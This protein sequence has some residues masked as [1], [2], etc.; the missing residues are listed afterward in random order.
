[1]FCFCLFQTEDAGEHGSAEEY[2]RNSSIEKA[3]QGGL[4][5]KC[6]GP[7]FKAQA[8]TV[9]SVCSVQISCHKP[10]SLK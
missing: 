2:Q 6:V 8:A 9:S 10:L 4:V 7:P 3:D 1:M 5:K